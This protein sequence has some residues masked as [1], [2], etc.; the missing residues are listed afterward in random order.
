MTVTLAP[1]VLLAACSGDSAPETTA[2]PPSVT[3]LAVTERPFAASTDFVGRTLAYQQVDILARVTGFLLKQGFED[4]TDIEE[5][6]IL[7]EID[8]SEFDAAVAAAQAGVEKAQAALTEAET[9]L[10]RTKTLADKGTVSQAELDNATAVAGQAKADLA[11]AEADLQTAKLNQS[12][13]HITSPISGRIGGSNVDVGNLIGPDSGTLSTVINLDPIRVSFSVAERTYLNF[14]E[15][16]DAGNA[17]D[18]EPRLQLANDEVYDQVGQLAFI[19]NQIDQGT[20]TVQVFVDFPNAKKLLLPGQFVN[21]ILTQSETVNEIMIPQ[22]AVQQN[23][24][25]PFVLVV[26]G[27]NTV[28]LHR[29]DVSSEPRR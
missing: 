17:P 11:A 14:I 27:D 26:G 3:V 4:G 24:V 2:P 25:G 19:D 29:R 20:G 28:E 6:T 23:Q 21:V 22:A 10:E 12:Y 1:A 9:T 8:P 5:G 15:A 13:T 7:Y 18:F 16:S